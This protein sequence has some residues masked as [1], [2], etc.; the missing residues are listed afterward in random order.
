M[1]KKKGVCFN[2]V[3]VTFDRGLLKKKKE[4]SNIILYNI[5]L[6]RI[7]RNNNMADINV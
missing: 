3:E 5:L 1:G 2:I 7:A 6:F 4:K